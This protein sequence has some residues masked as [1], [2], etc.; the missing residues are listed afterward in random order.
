TLE[1]EK[2]FAEQTIGENLKESLETLI[3]P[4]QSLGY[5]AFGSP[6]I[7][8]APVIDI[9]RTIEDEGNILFN[10]HNGGDHGIL[11]P[12]SSNGLGFQ[13]L[14]YIFLK[15]QY[16]CRS[17]LNVDTDRDVQPLHL[18]LIEE[19]EAHLHAQAQNIFIDKALEVI[20]NDQPKEIDSQLLVSTHSS[21]IANESEFSNLLY[22][23][24]EL[25]KNN[26]IA[27]VV[28]LSNVN[29]NP[30]FNYDE[31]KVRDNDDKESGNNEAN[32]KF[33]KRY[34]ELA[35]HDLFF[36]DAIILIEG[37]SERI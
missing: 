22:F 18:I 9:I 33:V 25:Y 35:E 12:E 6:T 26:H 37:S 36:A 16:F 20:R 17:R 10:P 21:H 3:S 31:K 13:N 30:Q 1:Y 19:P 14:I 7:D 29:M 24:R 28:D 8:V 4:L 32:E 23:K 2:Y 5:P 11:L 15:L 34:L 27:N